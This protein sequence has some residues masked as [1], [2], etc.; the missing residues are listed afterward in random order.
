MTVQPMKQAAAVPVGQRLWN[1]V[2]IL[3]ILAVAAVLR[4]YGLRWGL[5][6]D[7]HGYSYHPDE[8]LTVLYTYVNV[9]Q[10]GSLDPKFYNYPSLYLYAIAAAM[11][12]ALGVIP[13][14]DVGALYL[15]ARIVTVLM[16]VGSVLAVYWAAGKLTGR[17]GA[18]VAAGILCIAPLHVQHSHFATVD[19]PSTLFVALAL[20]FAVKALREDEWRWY[21]LA[22]L[23]S[24][25]AA[26]TKYNAGLVV[27]AIIA[28]HFF[29]RGKPGLRVASLVK[30]LAAVVVT[31]GA[32]VISTPSVFLN[33][34]GVAKALAYETKHTSTGHGLVF[35]GT[36]NGF[37]YTFTHSLWYGLGPC[38]AILFL[39][40]VGY[41]II[42]RNKPMLCILAFVIPYY[43]LISIS[44]VRFARYVLPLFP[45]I[46]IMCG[47]FVWEVWELLKSRTMRLRVVAGTVAGIALLMTL[48]YTVAL[49]SLFGQPDPRDRAAAWVKENIPAGSSIGVIDYPW[50]YSPPLSKMF[51]FGTESTRQEG[52]GQTPYR[53]IPLVRQQSLSD[54]SAEWYIDTDYET[55][56]A[57]RLF[58]SRRLTEDQRKEADA[59]FDAWMHMS[60]LIGGADDRLTPHEYEPEPK[61]TIFGNRLEFCRMRFGDTRLLPHDMKYVSPTIYVYGPAK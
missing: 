48:G 1:A 25:L 11:F 15:S 22:G 40:A 14:F 43:A 9:V 2:P 45:A 17:T 18:L 53:I 60:T 58:G 33:W 44:Q 46:A 27:F 10:A 55:E 50:F 12:M 20:G 30:P 34:S 7:A 54:V 32:F 57:R 51:G 4:F 24:G 5:P 35:A 26:G 6:N 23:M 38:L 29:G 49:D 37:V 47:W 31:V 28:A 3:C 41:A 19:V 21:L 39:A 61:E 59:K 52:M 13:A 36:G 16:G 56:D 8:F 42:R